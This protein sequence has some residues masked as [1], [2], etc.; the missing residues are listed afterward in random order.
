MEKFGDLMVVGVSC[1][2]AGAQAALADETIDVFLMADRLED[3]TG[4]SALKR[5]RQGNLHTKVVFYRLGGI[6]PLFDYMA[7]R[8]GA[9][10]VLP[11]SCGYSELV[12]T[13]RG[14]YEGT[15]EPMQSRM[16]GR[17]R[18]LSAREMDVLAGILEGKTLGETAVELGISDKTVGTYKNRLFH[19][20]G[21]KKRGGTGGN[22]QLRQ[23]G[24][25]PFPIAFH[26]PFFPLR[27]GVGVKE[28]K[29]VR[30]PFV[31]GG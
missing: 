24:G 3:C 25:V 31:K 23:W 20:L 6:S 27:G 8:Y 15:L 12:A 17:A 30:L 29:K 14:V 7:A 21:V 11:P 13:V 1:D 18:K 10:A 9:G 22:V 19:K 4:V 5:I 26:F 2:F 16:V 28:V